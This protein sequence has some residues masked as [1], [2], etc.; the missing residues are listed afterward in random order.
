MLKSKNGSTIFLEENCL[1]KNILIISL[2]SIPKI[3]DFQ[4][5]QY[6]DIASFDPKSGRV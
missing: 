4:V 1:D 6:H 3:E 5:Y 2:E